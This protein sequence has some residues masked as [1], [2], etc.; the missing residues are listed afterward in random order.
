MPPQDAPSRRSRQDG[1]P[2]PP[3]KPTMAVNDVF[4]AQ[5]NMQCGSTPTMN[6]LHM[7]EVTARAAD[8]NAPESV[9]AAVAAFYGDLAAQ[10]GEDWRVI[11]I[12]ANQI[13]P[14][15]AGPPAVTVFG[16]A[17]SIEGAI[18]SDLIPSNAPLVLSLYSSVVGNKGRG[19]IF[20][21][22]IPENEQN[23]GQI[24]A[25]YHGLVQG[26][27][28]A[29]LDETF[30]PP[31]PKTGSYAFIVWN[32]PGPGGVNMD[33]VSTIV[34]PNLANMRSR[35]AFEGFSA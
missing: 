29:H 14:P 10:L 9:I 23:D 17:E 20:L 21:P 15:A 13:S 4:R 33:V 7:R 34:R 2:G 11:S 32:P 27:C 12:R 22:G 30:V 18:V 24:T 35:R 31:A 25:S 8:E 1:G 28:N 3:G 5:I 6:I 16:G 19:R 26:I